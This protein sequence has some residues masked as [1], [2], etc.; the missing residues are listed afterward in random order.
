MIEILTLCACSVG[1]IRF[2]FKQAKLPPRE[3][4]T[5]MFS[6]SCLTFLLVFNITDEIHNDKYYFNVIDVQDLM[7]HSQL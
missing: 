3:Q 5:V 1:M 4:L 7:C 6:G 2:Q